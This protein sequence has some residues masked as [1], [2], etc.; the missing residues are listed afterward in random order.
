MILHAEGYCCGIVLGVQS[1]FIDKPLLDRTLSRGFTIGGVMFLKL[2]RRLI[3]ALAGQMPVCLNVTLLENARANR[4][5][6]PSA[7]LSPSDDGIPQA[8]FTRNVHFRQFEES[9]ISSAVGQV[10]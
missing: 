8:V 4:S 3:Y 6:E 7:G 10:V 5:A 2:R 9:E 1:E